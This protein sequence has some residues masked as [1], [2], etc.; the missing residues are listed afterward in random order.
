MGNF[1]V[2]CK[3]KPKEQASLRWLFVLTQTQLTVDAVANVV[4]FTSGILILDIR[5]SY[6]YPGP[7]WP[8]HHG[9][10]FSRELYETFKFC[11][12]S[13]GE[14]TS[15]LE[16]YSRHPNVCIWLHH[17]RLPVIADAETDP[18]YAKI[19]LYRRCPATWS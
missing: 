12:S 5:M 3:R 6:K 10:S 7:R 9:R 11:T 14:R 1:L 8:R 17:S 13:L 2:S 19:E 4:S 18:Q 16:T 15:R